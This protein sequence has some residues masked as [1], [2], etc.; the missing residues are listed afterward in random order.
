M[1]I[2][3]Y[4]RI[5]V[6]LDIKIRWIWCL[7]TNRI[8]ITYICTQVHVFNVKQQHSIEQSRSHRT[9]KNQEETNEVVAKRPRGQFSNENHHTRSNYKSINIFLENHLLFR[10]NGS[11]NGL[12]TSN[13]LSS[14]TDPI[15][16]LSLHRSA[17]MFNKN[18]EKESKEWRTTQKPP[19]NRENKI[20]IDNFATDISMYVF[21][22]K[23]VLYAFTSAGKTLDEVN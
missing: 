17:K 14:N 9:S 18:I 13:D 3:T 23:S 8:L 16:M 2:R 5:A 6:F 1:E 21:I 22:S 12:S 7:D 15:L 11:D 4:W 20:I 19:Q 10:D